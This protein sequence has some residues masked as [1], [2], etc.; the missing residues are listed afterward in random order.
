M[1]ELFEFFTPTF[2]KV[3]RGKGCNNL[4]VWF[5]APECGRVIHDSDHGQTVGYFSE[6][7]CM[8]HFET[9]LIN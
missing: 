4:L 1:T 9:V 3:M 7:W 8:S 5:I 6:T 2:P